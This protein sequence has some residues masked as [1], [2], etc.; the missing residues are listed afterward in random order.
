MDQRR[1]GSVNVTSVLAA[2]DLAPSLLSLAQVSPP[3][4]AM[5][6]GENLAPIL[7]GQSMESRRAPLFW[8]RPPDR[9]FAYNSG[10]FPD[11]AVREGNW[12]LLCSFDGTQPE[13]YDLEN[14][15]TEATNLASAHPDVVDRLTRF[16]L[17][18]NASM[19][20][21]KGMALGQEEIASAKQKPPGKA[22]KAK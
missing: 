1:A 19:P 16:V 6:D 8:R 18:W 17:D 4:G 11:L 20:Q 15:P 2:F 5:F 14:D 22:N 10:P 21:D 13:L 7:L 12:K 3:D 9:K